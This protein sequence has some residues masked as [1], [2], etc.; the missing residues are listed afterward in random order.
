MV[1][2]GWRYGLPIPLR[3]EVHLEKK[4]PPIPPNRASGFTL[5]ELVI[6]LMLLSLLTFS[7]VVN[8]ETNASVAAEADMLRAHLRFAQS[9]A[10]ANNTADW[11]VLFEGQSYT[12][13][14]DGATSPVPWPGE[15]GATHVLPNDVNLIGGVGELIF[16]VWGAPAADY[17]ITLSD[18]TRQEQVVVLGLTGLIP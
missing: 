11:S 10:I 16:D 7:V 14:R 15:N 6:V 1:G 12:L 3:A 8:S 4:S 9:L 2:R 17:T 13:R 5:L 18:G